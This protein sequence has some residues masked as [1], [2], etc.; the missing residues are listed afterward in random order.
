MT[1]TPNEFPFLEAAIERAR[2]NGIPDV[3]HALGANGKSA[4]PYDQRVSRAANS[5]E[6]V[7]Q[8]I[9]RNRN[10]D[11]WLVLL[12]IMETVFQ[13]DES[14]AQHEETR[15]KMTLQHFVERI[16]ELDAPGNATFPTTTGDGE[17]CIV[18]WNRAEYGSDREGLDLFTVL[19]TMHRQL[20]ATLGV[21]VMYH[22]LDY[23]AL[24]RLASSIRPGKSAQEIERREV[25]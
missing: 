20:P 16:I 19:R 24:S 13:R 6:D 18:T 17:P 9:A 3:F 8:A 22:D 15:G 5:L 4:R 12:A 21:E 14:L 23:D 2:R 7:A 1:K 10:I 11:P 25:S